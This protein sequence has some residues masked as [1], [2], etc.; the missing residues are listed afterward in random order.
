MKK[1][2]SV[3]AMLLML[4][5]PVAMSASAMTDSDFIQYLKDNDFAQEYIVFAENHFK[6]Y[7][8]SDTQL[9]DMKT[10]FENARVIVAEKNPEVITKGGTYFDR[11]KFTTEEINKIA[12]EIVAGAEALGVRCEIRKDPNSEWYF[13]FYNADGQKI[14]SAYVNPTLFKVTDGTP[15]GSA[16]YYILAAVALVAVVGGGAFLIKKRTSAVKA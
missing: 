11:S 1:I 3:L 4:T 14:A 10:H 2:I 12:D 7:S 9:D 16:V 5:I 13:E 15:T 8:Y 6:S